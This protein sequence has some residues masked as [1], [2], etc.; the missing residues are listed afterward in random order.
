M[1]RN[2]LIYFML[3]LIVM[4]M[5]LAIRVSGLPLPGFITT[6]GGDTLWALMIFLGL[7]I[8]FNRMPTLWSTIMA[9]LFCYSIEV[10]Q[11]YQGDMINSIRQTT[12]GGLI[13]GFGFLW[14]D[15]ICYT[16]GVGIGFLGESL[17]Y[18]RVKHME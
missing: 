15:I 11:L 18:A 8:V 7:G 6:Y 9:L 14:S 1:R 5:G 4:T 13:L 2:R 10:S 16:I 12:L 3:T 17:L